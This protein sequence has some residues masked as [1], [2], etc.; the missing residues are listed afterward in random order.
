MVIKD[1][2]AIVT[3]I[4]FKSTDSKQYLNFKSCR[5]KP[6]K[7]NIPF[8]LARRIC[9]IVSDRNILKEKRLQELA[10]TLIRRKYP[11]Q[12]IAMGIIKVSFA[13]S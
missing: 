10:A 2:T 4:Y 1:G 11:R 9:I 6:T 13:N 12:V 7:T 8:S 5:Q 3:D